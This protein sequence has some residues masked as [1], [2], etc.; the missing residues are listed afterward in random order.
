MPGGR[1]DVD[2]RTTLKIILQE[3]GRSLQAGFK[4]LRIK[5]QWRVLVQNVTSFL[6]PQKARIFKSK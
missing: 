6:V 4:W 2:E 5:D 3:E 1:Q